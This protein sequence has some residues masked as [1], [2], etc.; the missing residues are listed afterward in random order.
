MKWIEPIVFSKSSGNL[1]YRRTDG[2]TDRRTDRHRGESSIPP[3]HLQW[4]GG[5][6][7][8]CLPHITGLT[9]YRRW[10]KMPVRSLW[11][12]SNAKD[13]NHPHLLSNEER[14]K[15]QI[16]FY[17]LETNAFSSNG[18]KC[19]QHKVYYEFYLHPH[20]QEVALYCLVFVF[21]IPVH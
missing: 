17:F 3:F 13:S 9:L 4:S 12:H 20:G 11:R 5:I 7:T 16:Y 18:N 6:N 2:R 10:F 1:V 21:S 15:I 8:V 19:I 14:M